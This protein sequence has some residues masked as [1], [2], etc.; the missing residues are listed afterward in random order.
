MDVRAALKGQYRAGLEML[1]Q[2]VEVCPEEIWVSGGHP[3]NFWRIAYHAV[4]YAHL[5][6]QPAFE[7]FRPWDMTREDATNLWGENDALEPYSRAE[8]L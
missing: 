5:Y 2:T 1:R 3:R 8:I 4:F 7:E 6:I